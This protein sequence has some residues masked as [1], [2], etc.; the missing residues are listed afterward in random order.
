MSSNNEQVS[1]K[2][3]VNHTLFGGAIGYDSPS[4]YYSFLKELN[5]NSA[6]HMLIASVNYAQTKGVYSLQEAE[7]IAASI[8]T[9]TT[10][11]QTTVSQEDIPTD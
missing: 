10:P 2:K 9:F 1:E 3:P 5:K 6:L 4:D 11:I 7:L 8:R